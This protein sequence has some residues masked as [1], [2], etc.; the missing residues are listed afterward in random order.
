MEAVHGRCRGLDSFRAAVNQCCGTQV[1]A[2]FLLTANLTNT[3][4]MDR[5]YSLIVSVSVV[6]HLCI[7][8]S[9]DALVVSCALPVSASDIQHWVHAESVTRCSTIACNWSATGLSCI[10]L[11]IV[12]VIIQLRL[13]LCTLSS[14]PDIKEVNNTLW[15]LPP[16]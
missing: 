8:I 7:N 15:L 11:S 2:S 1:N 9:L 14:H 16:L 12:S 5:L 13:M 10:T 6:S 3:T 4:S